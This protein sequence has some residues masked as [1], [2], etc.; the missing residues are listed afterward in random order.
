VLLRLLLGLLMLCM[1]LGRFLPGPPAWGF[2]HLFYLPSFLTPLWA[3]AAVVVF[4]PA[5]QRRALDLLRES[6]PR[7]LFERRAGRWLLPLIGGALF[8]LLRERSFFMGDGYLIGELADRGVHFRAF[9]SLDYLLH[10]QALNFLRSTGSKLSSFDVYR[11]ASMVAGLLATMSLPL[12][13]RRLDWA[14][15]RKA[16][17]LALLFCQ[18]PAALYFGYVESYSYLFLFLTCFM[19]SGLLVLDGR[20]ALWVASIFYGLALAFHLTAVFTGPALLFLALRAPVRPAVKRWLQ[21]VVPPAALFALAV[22]LH[23]AEGYNAFWFRKEFLESKNSQSLWIPLTGSYGLLSL[24]TWKDFVNLA[25]ITA[26][27]CLMVAASQWRRIRARCREPQVLFLGVQIAVV[28]VFGLL[29]D[30]KLGGARDWDLLAAHVSGL[31][32]LAAMFLPART[33]AGAPTEARPEP[34]AATKPAGTKPVKPGIRPKTPPAPAE[35]PAPVVAAVLGTAFLLAAPWVLLLHLEPRS[36]DRFVAVAA[37]FPNF[38]RAYSYEEVGKYY[39]KAEDMT[40]ARLMYEKCVQSYPGNPR[41]RVLLGSIYFMSQQ[42]DKAEGEYLAAVA[43]DS[44]YTMAMEMLGKVALERKDPAGALVWFRRL[45]RLKPLEASGWD[46]L[47]YAASRA[48]LPD[49][50]VRAYVQ[51][52]ALD[53]RINDYHDLGVSL[54][55]MQRYQDAAVAF[56]RCLDRGETR[57]A[58]HLGLAWSLTEAAADEARAGRKPPAATLDEA[59][60]QIRILAESDSCLTDA[61]DLSRKLQLLRQAAGR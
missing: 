10:L 41:F 39:R 23:L 15:W 7:F 5:V 46:M 49:E 2:N 18:G 14:P 27:V 24:R 40:R 50:A 26:P 19:I 54:L 16:A 36:I 56:R 34:P 33:V 52:M 38:A 51:A 60:A 20:G 1:F 9:D 32:L 47:G 25:L 44:T 43:R 13:I 21:A 35:R 45:V 55:S 12:L 48:R 53:P 57:A 42:Y 4:W 30:R 29:V 6:I 28:G 3:L 59:E 61:N 11:L 58:T 17:L 8:F 22:A 31:V 37:D